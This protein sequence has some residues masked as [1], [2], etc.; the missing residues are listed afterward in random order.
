MIIRLL[1]KQLD[2]S[3]YCEYYKAKKIVVKGANLNFQIDGEPIDNNYRVEITVDPLSLNILVP[4]E[5]N[6][7]DDSGNHSFGQPI[8][9]Q[10]M[11]L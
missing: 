3:R 1:N 6:R 7:T 9:W 4:K 8:V 5:V 11:I 2:S 10:R